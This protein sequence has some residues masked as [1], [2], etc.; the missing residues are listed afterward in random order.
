MRLLC[1][2]NEI[3]ISVDTTNFEYPWSIPKPKVWFKLRE[4][5]LKTTYPPFRNVNFRADA[6]DVY[7]DFV[8]IYTD[9][10]KDPNTGKTGVAFYVEPDEIFHW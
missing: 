1:N 6:N 8:H 3:S 4:E 10:S 9:G 2:Q 7:S 5:V